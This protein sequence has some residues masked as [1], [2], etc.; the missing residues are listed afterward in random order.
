MKDRPAR[1]IF[2]CTLA[3]TK[4]GTFQLVSATT[5]TPVVSVLRRI[6]VYGLSAIPLLKEGG[7]LV[8]VYTKGDVQHLPIEEVSVFWLR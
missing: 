4:L 7:Q 6:N 2:S 8:D 3:E 1:D 5:S